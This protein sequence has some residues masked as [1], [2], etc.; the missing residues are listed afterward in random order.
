MCISKEGEYNMTRDPHI[1]IFRGLSILTMVAANAAPQLLAEPHP[2]YFRVYGTFAAAIFT[3]LAGMMIAFGDQFKKYNFKHYLIR[4]ALIAMVGCFLD[5]FVWK[6]LP[7]VTYDILFCIGISTP[8]VYVIS[9]LSK[10]EIFLA[11]LAILALGP[12]LQ[13]Q[14]GYHIEYA[15]MPLLIPDLWQQTV[16]FDHTFSKILSNLFV[17]GDFPIFPWTGIMTMGLFFGKLRYGT[18]PNE[19]QPARYFPVAIP[20]LAGG[21]FYWSL[22]PGALSTRM[23]WSE[24]FYPASSGYLITALGVILL[25]LSLVDL[26]PHQKIRHLKLVTTLGQSSL[27]VYWMHEVI[28]VMGLNHWIH[29]QPITSFAII[30][31]MLLAALYAL[32]SKINQLKPRMRNWALPYRF[33]FNA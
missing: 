33:V 16:T 19:I 15:Q 1:D 13:S 10:E 20:L 22:N 2:F 9:K 3:F 5:V 28:I 23:G 25:L 18:R 14:L 29:P 7:F 21:I 32:T 8:I 27:F 4:G 24:L 30:Y 17:N 31:I 6:M 12:L 11:G 26:I